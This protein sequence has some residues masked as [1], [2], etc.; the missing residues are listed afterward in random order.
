MATSE[1]KNRGEWSELFVLVHL[2]ASGELN[3]EN[4]DSSSKNA[5]FPVILVSRRVGSFEHRFRI[6][7]GYVEILNTTFLSRSQIASVAPASN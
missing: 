6:S 2:L 5:A 3:Y 1:K 4:S 7:D